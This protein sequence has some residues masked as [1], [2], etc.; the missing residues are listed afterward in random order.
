MQA[1]GATADSGLGTG[2]CTLLAEHWDV[3][4]DE[5]RFASRLWSVC[6]CSG[7]RFPSERG[8]SLSSW[9]SFMMNSHELETAVRL[10]LDLVVLIIEDFAHGMNPLEANGRSIS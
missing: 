9:F 10:K 3:L 5:A 7:P 2:S 1:A 8:Q 6:R 4:Q